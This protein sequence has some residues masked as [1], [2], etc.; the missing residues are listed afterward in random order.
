LNGKKS[1]TTYIYKNLT[2]VKKTQIFNK[3]PRTP[4][5]VKKKLALATMHLH[6]MFDMVKLTALSKTHYSR[7]AR[8][9][10]KNSFFANQQKQ[11]VG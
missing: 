6:D 10:G 3:N 7:D 1:N 8:F 5:L 2:R 4:G 9:G 11:T